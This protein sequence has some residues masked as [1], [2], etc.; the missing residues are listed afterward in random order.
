V[1]WCWP[2][3]EKRPGYQSGSESECQ[4]TYCGFYFSAIPDQEPTQPDIN[5]LDT[6]KIPYLQGISFIKSNTLPIP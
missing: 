3:I 2:V 4:I 6:L 1:N 5:V